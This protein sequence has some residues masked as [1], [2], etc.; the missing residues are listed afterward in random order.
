MATNYTSQVMALAAVFQVS[1]LVDDIAKRNTFNQTCLE[2]SIQSLFIMTPQTPDQ[3][4]GGENAL[5]FNLATGLRE[6]RAMLEKDEDQHRDIVRY[7]IS[8]LH[9]ERKLDGRSDML[10]QI[11]KKIPDIERQATFFA[12]GED[13]A[14]RDRYCHPTVLS[15]LAGLYQDT[16][17]TFSFRIQVAGNPGHLRDA[18]NVHR[19]RALLLA[20][21][22]AARQWRQLGG[23]RWQLIFYR[24]KLLE[25]CIAL[26]EGRN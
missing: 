20:G 21:I 8:L 5:R 18:T 23:R 24:R 2:T 4:Y 10:E 3:V 22:R 1:R 7:S 25:A 17:S 6:L 11:A 15:A 9:L 16:L 19:I 14:E 26:Q 12:E 13:E